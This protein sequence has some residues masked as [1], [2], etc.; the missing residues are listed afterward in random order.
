[1]LLEQ[2]KTRLLTIALAWHNLDVST[3]PASIRNDLLEAQKEIED[4]QNEAR[5]SAETTG[6]RN[7][8]ELREAQR[9][10]YQRREDAIVVIRKDSPDFIPASLDLPSILA[11]IPER[12]ALVAPL[13]TWHG[14]AVFVI[15]HGTKEI[16]KDHV[17]WIDDFTERDLNTLLQGP[18]E[19]LFLG[20]GWMG[21]YQIFRKNP[22]SMLE[23]WQKIIDISG[24]KMWSLL[25]P[26]HALLAKLEIQHIILMP[27]GGLQLLPL[28]A[29]WREINGEQ[30]YFLDDFESIRYAPSAYA[31]D[32][33]ER[34]SNKP[35]SS[36]DAL[37]VG[38]N[39]YDRLPPLHNAR[40]EAEAI[41]ATLHSQPLLDKAA[42]KDSICQAATGKAYLHFS[43]HGAFAWDQDPLASA[44]YLAHDE[45]LSLSEII[46]VMNL[47][48][49]RLVTLSACETGVID[50]RQSPDE[51]VGL[52]AGFLRAGAPAVISSL[53]TVDDRSTALLMEKFYYN[54]LEE[55]MLP[56]RA[57]YKAQ[58]WLRDATRDEIGKYYQSHL[59]MTNEQ[60]NE[61]YTEITT[62]GAP[63]E[64]PY[65]HPF[66]WAAFTFTGA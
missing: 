47:N 46:G 27:Q 57:L 31:L 3:L 48:S 43:C 30:C 20:S 51:Y 32:V 5:L 41:A 61:G 65:A 60:A 45:P 28:H 33:C 26:V 38:I 14:S 56:A 17:L 24:R 21:I 15:P 50:V 29:A 49:A 39:E 4:L 54:F 64:K 19:S 58:L 9:Q 59:R 44:L 63:N 18:P 34:R 53:W 25:A 2:G 11:L 66:Y 35:T 1:M 36:R 62:R 13:V 42:S 23:T 6:R 55:G 7:D 16:E 37:V 40:A 52:P 22:L 8:S 10:A 12:G